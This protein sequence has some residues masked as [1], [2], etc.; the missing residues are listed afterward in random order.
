MLKF[1]ITFHWH[2]ILPLISSRH[3]GGLE[4]KSATRR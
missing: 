1:I 4:H 3:I 2:L